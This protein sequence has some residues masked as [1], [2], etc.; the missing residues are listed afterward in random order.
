MP[1]N[2][3]RTA[4]PS[5]LPLA[6]KINVKPVLQI[7]AVFRIKQILRLLANSSNTIV[8]GKGHTYLLVI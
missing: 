7:E 2:R 5:S 3:D 6:D 4:V 1:S 8:L